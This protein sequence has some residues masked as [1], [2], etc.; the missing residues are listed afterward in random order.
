MF[1]EVQTVTSR[2]YVHLSG[3]LAH[4]L[5]LYLGSRQWLG[6][7]DPKM[8]EDTCHAPRRMQTSHGDR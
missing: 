5:S 7:G 4:L 2:V 6:P 3:H 1:F 8:N